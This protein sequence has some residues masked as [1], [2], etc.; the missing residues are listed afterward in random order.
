M[1]FEILNTGDL[2]E[3]SF[4]DLFCVLSSAEQ[5]HILKY[6][7]E[8]RRRVSL[9]AHIAVKQGLKKHFGLIDAQIKY[10]ANGKPYVEAPGVYFSISHSKDIIAVAFSKNPIGIDVEHVK[11]ISQLVKDRVC[12]GCEKKFV[13]KNGVEGFMVVWTLKEA[14]IKS[15]GMRL[16]D[17]SKIRLCFGENITAKGFDNAELKYMIKDGYI[18]STCELK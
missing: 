16:S 10:T 6:K 14:L 7:N 4:D 12:V 8:A 17:I 3:N 2:A 18:L 5:I 13:K 1:F 9:L 15:N 11:N